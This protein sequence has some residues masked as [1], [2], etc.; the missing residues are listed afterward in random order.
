ME[1]ELLLVWQVVNELSDQL[2]TNQKLAYNLQSQAGELKNQATQATSGFALRRVNADISKETFE[3]EL[4]R[5]NAQTIIENQTL[6]HENKQLSLLLKEY[7]GTMETIMSK[8]RNHALAAQQHELTLTRHYEALLHSRDTQNLDNG[9]IT[10]TILSESLQ[11]LA[12]Y[13]RGLLKS[14]AGENYENLDPDYDGSGFG[15]A[16]IEELHTLLEALDERSGYQGAEGSQD[17]ALE[18]ECEI[19]RLEKEN[20]E[21]RRL[22]GIDDANMAAQ[23]VSVDQDRVESGRYSTFLSSSSRRRASGDIYSQR[24]SCWDNNSQPL[25]QQQQQQQQLQ[26]QQPAP[27]PPSQRAMELQPGM[28]AGPQARRAGMFGAA[29]QRGGFLGGV[30]RAMAIGV[31]T[32]S[33]SSTWSNPVP[34]SPAT[35]I[36]TD[37]LW[38][39]QAS[40]GDLLR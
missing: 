39:P 7:E 24:S 16:N 40:A 31:G 25:Q 34:V 6:L 10:N 9:L 20:E 32:P 30:G 8:F 11:R 3:S 1:N 12:Y 22:L 26:L 23:G 19:L 18:R 37:R 14:M 13:L 36:T 33:S 15:F 2:A 27:A 29:H 28:R 17:W 38:H 4:E 21:L 35:P 5:M